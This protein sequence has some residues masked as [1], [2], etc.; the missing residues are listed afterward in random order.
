VRSHAINYAA[1][2]VWALV[3]CATCESTG[4]VDGKVRMPSLRF[5]KQEG[6]GNVVL[7]ASSPDLQEY[8]V[9]YASRSRLG[10]KQ[11]E[12]EFNLLPS[13]DALQVYINLYSQAPE[14]DPI[15]THVVPGP[16]DEYLVSTWKARSGRVRVFLGPPLLDYD[17]TPLETYRARVVLED[18]VFEDGDGRTVQ[19]NA[20]IEIE[21]EVGWLLG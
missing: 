5:S 21:A 16:G 14:D 6:Y 12:Q 7:Y 3:G 20:S 4:D 15:C 19:Q 17:D 10:L 18:C 11:G 1:F 9:V 13:N 2:M 8:L